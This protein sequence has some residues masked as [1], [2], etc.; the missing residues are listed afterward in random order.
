MIFIVN[1]NYEQ[2]AGGSKVYGVTLRANDSKK[3]DLVSRKQK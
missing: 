3:E 1:N 2:I